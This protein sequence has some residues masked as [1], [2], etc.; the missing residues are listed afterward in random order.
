MLFCKQKKNHQNLTLVILHILYFKHIP[1]NHYGWR[2]NSVMKETMCKT[3]T[4]VLQK[5]PSNLPQIITQN[6]TVQKFY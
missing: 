4:N 5:L 1:Q 2:P 3:V 6:P